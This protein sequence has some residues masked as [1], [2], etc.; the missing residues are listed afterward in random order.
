MRTNNRAS[1][2]TKVKFLRDRPGLLELKHELVAMVLKQAGFYSPATKE[3]DIA[4]QALLREA[5]R[6]PG[7]SGGAPEGYVD[8]PQD[9][10]KP[11]PCE[12]RE[13]AVLEGVRL[14]FGQ[15]LSC[16]REIGVT[17]LLHGLREQA[18]RA[19]SLPGLPDNPASQPRLYQAQGRC[20]VSATAACPGGSPCMQSKGPAGQFQDPS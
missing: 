18:K 10:K 4:V 20:D 11:T 3:A 2:A 7:E 9:S 14:G 6:A 1:R 19:I 15:C 17:E 5:R 12:H 8:L 16:H 13:W